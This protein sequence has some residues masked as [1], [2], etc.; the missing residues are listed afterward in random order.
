VLGP[1]EQQSTGLALGLGELDALLPD[2]GLPRGSVVELCVQ[3][4]AAGATR[5]AL[6]ACRAAQAE[7]RA[8]GG[9]TPWCAFV[10][11]SGSLHGPGVAEAGVAL[12]RLL[13]VRPQRE[14]LSRVSLR[15]V[16]SRAFA[17]VVIDTMGAP[18]CP[19]EVPLGTWPRVVRRLAM[20]VEG[21]ES[22][23][24]LVTDSHASRPLPLPVAQRLELARV[25][26]HELGVR[27]AKDK[28]GRVSGRQRVACFLAA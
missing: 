4:A 8:R 22:S 18:G 2:G 7:G 11:A 24:L 26:Q 14:A 28:H 6:A 19:V 1:A 5:I 9:D 13:V 3:G 16:E 25:G 12:E 10:D 15:V 17:L 20:A 21:T 23:V 27:V